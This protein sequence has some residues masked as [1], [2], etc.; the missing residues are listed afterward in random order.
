[1][2][3]KVNTTTANAWTPKIQFPTDNYILRCIGEEVGVSQSSGNPMV[4]LE[5]EIVNCEPKQIGDDLIDFDGVKFKSYHVTANKDDVEKSDKAF[6]RHQE[7]ILVPCGIDVSEGWDDEN[8]PSVKGK[9]VHALIKGEENK[10][11]APPTK[12]EREAGKKV[13]KVL[14]DPITGKDLVIYKPVLSIV[15][16]LF[17]GEVKRPY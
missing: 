5:W 15:Y 16:G 2:I 6:K 17:E 3:R 13:G 10:S 7:G 12:E 11:Y 14:Q 8:P 9:V 1:M 4:T